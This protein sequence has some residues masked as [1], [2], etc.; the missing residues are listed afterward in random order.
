MISILWFF[1]SSR[2]IGTFFRANFQWR[3]D[4]FEFCL[5][6]FTRNNGNFLLI[7]CFV[8][9]NCTIISPLFLLSLIQHLEFHKYDLSRVKYFAVGGSPL[10][11]KTFKK[12]KVR[13]RFENLN[14]RNHQRYQRFLIP[15]IWCLFL[16][17]KPLQK[18]DYKR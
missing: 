7:F 3:T 10:T 4:S 11:E 17:A 6:M 12:I 16:F 18:L 2:S 5:V 8:Q 1:I 9:V 15:R 13:I 14:I